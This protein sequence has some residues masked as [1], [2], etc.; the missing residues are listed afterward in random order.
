MSQRDDIKAFRDIKPKPIEKPDKD[1]KVPSILKPIEGGSKP[2]VTFNL[3]DYWN[4]FIMG[5]EGFLTRKAG[6][7]LG[8][9]VPMWV[10]VTLVVGILLLLAIAIL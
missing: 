4:R 2:S 9:L 5:L 3:S 10:W 8:Y 1:I 6:E 7:V